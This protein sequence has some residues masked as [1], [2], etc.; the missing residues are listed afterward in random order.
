VGSIVVRAAMLAW[1]G[2]AL[3]APGASAHPPP[4][5]ATTP[6]T[7]VGPSSATLTGVVTPKGF[8][9]AYFFQYGTSS[10]EAR[11]PIASAGA[12]REPVSVS[13]PVGNLA[14]ATTY[15]V[16][17][18]AFNVHRIAAGGD[19]AFATPSPAPPEPPPPSPPPPALAPLPNAPSVLVPPPPLLYER[20]NV[21][22]RSGTVTVKPPGGDGFARL[23]EF[24]SIPVGSLV[25][26]SKGSVVLHAATVGGGT[27][28]GT[29]HGGVFEVRQPSAAR[30]TTELVLRGRLPG[31]RRGAAITAQKRKRRRGLWGNAHG[32][33][34]TRG[35]NSVAT[36]RG[37]VWYVEDRCN[38]T[39][40]RVKRG[41]VSVRDLRRHR[42]V[43]VRAGRRYLARTRR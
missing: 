17:L 6:P 28:S 27:Q 18:V 26:A 37:T 35:S 2:L 31:C 19:V 23:S 21:A 34:R 41:S 42:T 32:N 11:T 43:V 20:V 9:T 4:G 12:G 14:P 25:D 29:F 15:H 3:M 13:A 30:G 36:V 7:D 1:A 40:T 10:Y 39:L 24:A 5:A 8:E 22:V 38:A 16:R 33:F